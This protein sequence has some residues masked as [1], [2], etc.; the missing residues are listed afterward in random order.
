MKIKKIPIAQKL[1]ILDVCYTLLFCVF[2]A[3]VCVCFCTGHFVIVH[4]NLTCLLCLQHVFFVHLFNLYYL[5]IVYVYVLLSLLTFTPTS[6]FTNVCSTFFAHIYP[7]K[8]VYQRLFYFL[9]SHLPPQASLPT[10]VLLS[11]LTFTPTSQLTN[12]CSTFFAHIYPYKPVNQR[13]Q[14]RKSSVRK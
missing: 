13:Q 9:C 1:F 11:L 6:Q 14:P 5:N 2:C 8:P 10:S 4:L 7:H 12:V 3:V